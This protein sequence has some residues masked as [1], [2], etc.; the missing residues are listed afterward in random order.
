MSLRDIDHAARL[1]QVT[2]TVAT[3][4]E[5][6]VR[7]LDRGGLGVLLLVHED[8]SLAALLTDGD[9]R[10]A[11]LQGRPLT[12]PSE[13]IATRDPV[14][15]APTIP[16]VEALRL[17]DTARPFHINQLPLVD[18]ARRPV[19]LLLR[20]DMVAVDELGLSAV[21]MAGGVGSRLH[22][23]TADTPK[24]MLPVGGR[25]VM[26]RIIR[27]LKQ[28]GIRDVSISTHYLSEKIHGHFRDGEDFGVQIQYLSEDRP[29]GTAG[30]LS[31]LERP[32]GPV[33]VLNGDILTR[34]DYRAML[35]FHQR[36][37]AAFTVGVRQFELEVPYGVVE[38]DG[39]VVRSI[40]EKP[41]LEFMVNAAVYLLEP[42]I[43]DLVPC[44]ERSDMNDLITLALARGEKVV[45][46]P[47]V[48]YWL[49]IGQP[50]D[51]AK[52]QEDAEKGEI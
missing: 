13:E 48:E 10:R 8:G 7:R 28:A 22:P 24:P 11:L 1:A 51:Y 27:Q 23:L 29:L 46:F 35:R 44:G 34:V 15:A 6:V 41:R 12:G 25:P 18:D 38:A 31:L 50:D 26:E 49:D 19:G 20:T 33:L 43:L 42:R 21:V 45:S 40:V 39:P 36:Q 14:V 47:I 4:I 32:S 37:K 9:L 3:P 5:D 30:G 2:V 52:A 17:M 16:A